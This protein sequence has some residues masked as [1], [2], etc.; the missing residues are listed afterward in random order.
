MQPPDDRGHG[1]PFDASIRRTETSRQ[2]RH[3]ARP[4]TSAVEGRLPTAPAL[5]LGLWWAEVLLTVVFRP[6]PEMRPFIYPTP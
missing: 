1:G 6:H 2:T 5:R 3:C 4:A